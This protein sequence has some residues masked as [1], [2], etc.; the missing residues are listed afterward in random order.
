MAANV[1]KL[2]ENPAL[3]KRFLRRLIELL[4][5]GVIRPAIGARLPFADAGRAME[6]LRGRKATGKIVLTLGSGLSMVDGR[7][8]TVGSP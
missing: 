3:L 5:Q 6:L 2:D 8:S 1:S 7:R 4:G